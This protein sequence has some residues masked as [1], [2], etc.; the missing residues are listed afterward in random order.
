MNRLILTA[1]LLIA[2]VGCKDEKL[3]QI[4]TDPTVLRAV[5]IDLYVAEA[6]LQSLPK[7]KVDS[8]IQMYRGQ[9]ADLHS[10]DM[11]VVD[12]DLAIIQ[13]RPGM[14][15]QYQSAIEDSLILLEK[16]FDKSTPKAME[17]K[18]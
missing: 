13:K 10:V 3:D 2:C 9:I 17:K 14:W 15:K 16:R 7:E 18:K 5:L 1:L 4:Q 12:A 8:L 11:A 6:A